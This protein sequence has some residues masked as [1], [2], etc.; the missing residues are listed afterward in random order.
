MIALYFCITDHLISQFWTALLLGKGLVH[1]LVIVTRFEKFG[2]LVSAVVIRSTIVVG[3]GGD[4]K[5]SFKYR[6]KL[7]KAKLVC[8]VLRSR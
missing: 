4:V 6:V 8:L 2:F 3:D 7:S 5:L 1:L